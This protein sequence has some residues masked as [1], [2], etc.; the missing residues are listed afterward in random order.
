MAFSFLFTMNTD[1]IADIERLIDF[2]IA[3]DITDPAGIIPTGDHSA[4][5]CLPAGRTGSGAVAGG[6][7]AQGGRDANRGRIGMLASPGTIPAWK[8]PY[9]ESMRWRTLR[10][11]GSGADRHENH[12]PPGVRRIAVCAGP[13]LKKSGSVGDG[14]QRR[15]RQYPG[16]WVG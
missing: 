8:E 9:A 6:Q 1:H 5:A 3:E 16:G 11:A 14:G 4:L 12:V 15:S 2:A 7:R 10:R 13:S